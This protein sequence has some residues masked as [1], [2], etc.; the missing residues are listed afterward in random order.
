MANEEG[1]EMGEAA[2]ASDMAWLDVREPGALQSRGGLCA[3]QHLALFKGHH[4]L[5]RSE[6]V[7]GGKGIIYDVNIG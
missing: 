7:V 1:S 6:N 3:A 4:S 2:G 5:R